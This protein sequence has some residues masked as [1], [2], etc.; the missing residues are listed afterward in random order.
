MGSKIFMA[1]PVLLLMLVLAYPVADAM[2]KKEETPYD[3][4]IVQVTTNSD[5]SICRWGLC[6]GEDGNIPEAGKA[7][8]DILMSGGGMYLGDINEQ[9][10]FMY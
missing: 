9:S 2:L 3:T 10:I 1:M 7:E 6:R 5:K 4:E 8:V